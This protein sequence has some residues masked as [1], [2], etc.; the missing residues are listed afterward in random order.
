[1]PPRLVE[2]A[3]RLRELRGNLECVFRVPLRCCNSCVASSAWSWPKRQNIRHV[4]ALR[5]ILQ[6]GSIYNI[7]P[8]DASSKEMKENSD[9]L[10]A[11]PSNSWVGYFM[12]QSGRPIKSRST[13]TSPVNEVTFIANCEALSVIDCSYYTT[14]MGKKAGPRLREIS[15]WPCLAVA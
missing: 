2:I 9:P 10:L 6:S 3:E 7:E 1:M 15:A 8:G 5:P 4:L 11:N 13:N 14:E 12:W